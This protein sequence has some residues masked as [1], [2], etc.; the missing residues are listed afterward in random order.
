MGTRTSPAGTLFARGR[1][2]TRRVPW[3][4]VLA[5]AVCAPIVHTQGLPG[6]AAISAPQPEAPKDLLGR[7]TPRGTVLAFIAAGRKG[8]N[9]LARRYLNTP[10][11]G[12]AA[13]K[14]AH[15]LFVVLDARLPPRL[16][17]VS[18]SPEGSRANPL[19]PDEEVV[20]T[21]PGASGPVEV[22][23][24]RVKQPRGE[25]IWLFSKRTLD[26]M[27]AEFAE[28]SSRARPYLPRFL[29]EW[30]VGNVRLYEWLTV[31]IGLPIFF[32]ITALVNRALRP[33]ARFTLR[34]V[35]ART[36]PSFT[37]ALPT[38]IRL[39]LLAIAIRWLIAAMPL[40][41]LVRQSLSNLAVIV[42][43]VG[44]AW[45]TIVANGQLER[46]FAGRI[47]RSSH[48]G[49]VSL[50]RVGR[51]LADILIV[52]VAILGVLRHY[53]VDP[54]PLLAGLGVG[55]IAIALAAQKTLENI[56]AGASL[57]FDEAVVIGDYLR[58]GTI[59][60]TVENIGL[61]ST[62]IRTLDRSLVTVPNSQI[63]NLSLE[64]LSARDKFW[65]H[66]I[67]GL[68]Y[69]TTAEQMQSVLDGTRKLLA[70]HAMIE[71]AS[72]RV[73]FKNMGAYSL[74]VDVFA[75]VLA[76]DWGH[77]LEIQEELL[78]A[79]SG[80]VRAAGT[81]VA[82]PSQTMYVQNNVNSQ[83]SQLPTPN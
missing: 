20:G 35:F 73:R 62:R 7:S 68:R 32:L 12:D 82:F 59:E 75:Y 28:V 14:Q 49:A 45:L 19:A 74:D 51:R 70:R 27:P 55:G 64:T 13:E 57:I 16:T 78:M 77:Y 42:A 1:S 6:A 40:S 69:E 76:R 71:A 15:Q 34:R 47:P 48:A 36:D 43:I 52:M 25:P 65:F 58:V 53:G 63:A 38:P 21:I 18:D 61:R 56:I 72:V 50:L 30:S 8:D 17:Q 22:V 11:A 79:I 26:A 24:E 33:I 67:L 37:H 23:V 66:P 44:L 4:L 3:A 39:L 29:F 83:T 10:L 80:I 5:L 54:T 46:Y 31:L 41:L 2:V 81:D 9:D 60:G